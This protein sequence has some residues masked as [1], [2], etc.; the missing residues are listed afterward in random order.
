MVRGQ[1]SVVRGQLSVA[2]YASCFVAVRQQ[3]GPQY[4]LLNLPQQRTT[5]HGLMRIK[6]R[7]AIAFGALD[8][9]VVIVVSQGRFADAGHRRERLALGGWSR[10]GRLLGGA[11]LGRSTLLWRF[12]RR[13]SLGSLL[14][15]RLLSGSALGDSLLWR[16]LCRALSGLLLCHF[17]WLLP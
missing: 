13:S 7:L 11:L 2:T 14:L 15:W 3:P 17:N 5:D 8:Q 10:S 6:N 12:L 16:L 1:L 4:Y 9:P